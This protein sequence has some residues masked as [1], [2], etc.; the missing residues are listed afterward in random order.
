MRRR[1]FAMRCARRSRGALAIIG[2]DR[3]FD[4]AIGE[5]MGALAG[6]AG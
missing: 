5:D 2:N 4:P 1:M 6:A 3:D